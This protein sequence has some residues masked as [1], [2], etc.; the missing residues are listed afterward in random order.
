MIRRGDLVLEEGLVIALEQG[1]EKGTRVT[2]ET[3][4]KCKA[5]EAAR[6]GFVTEAPRYVM[7][8]FHV[9]AEKF[10]DLVDLHHGADLVLGKRVVIVDLEANCVDTRSGK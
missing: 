4:Q 2:V 8:T 3:D 10:A 1:G 9:S 5:S 7:K 6:V